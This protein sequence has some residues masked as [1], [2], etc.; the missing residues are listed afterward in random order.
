MRPCCVS[1][2]VPAAVAVACVAWS[3]ALVTTTTTV[4]G[5]RGEAVI[6]EDDAGVVHINTSEPASQSVYV[7]GVDVAE[8]MD[9]VSMQAGTL[10]AQQRRVQALC[11]RF[12]PPSVDTTSIPDAASDPRSR[13]W[14]G[15]V[16][17]PDGLLYG[18]PFAWNT[19]LIVD[20]QTKTMDRTTISGADAPGNKWGNG[21]LDVDTGLIFAFPHDAAAVLIINP[22]T[23]AID[24][25]TMDGLPSGGDKWLS[26]VQADNGLIYSVPWSAPSVL[27]IDPKTNTTDMSTIMGLG[28]ESFKW[29]GGA[30][31]P[32]NGLIYCIPRAA[33]AV[34]IIDPSTNTVDMSSMVVGAAGGSK[35]TGGVLA[36]SNG[37]IYGIPANAR[38]VLVID[39]STNTADNT[40][41]RVP[42][43]GG[44]SAA[45]GAGA[46]DNASLWWG[47]V[48]ARN[49]RIL[50]VPFAAQSVLVIDPVSQT[51]DTT[52]LSGILPDSN[53]DDKW[54]AGAMSNGLIACTPRTGASVLFINPGC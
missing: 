37:L 38:A 13:G 29:Y 48:L 27:I 33:A 31:A 50:G 2:I 44:A 47:G 32:S 21:V 15:F 3:L 52:T 34:L 10:Q 17:G 8:L 28:R 16:A 41:L 39:P 43:T 49:G 12:N 40:T 14:H 5:V 54:W 36:P 30:L 20:T 42:V 11:Q 22:A 1:A 23:N 6:A 53:N 4:A 7:N 35:W 19:V 9:V 18:I 26:G 24:T 45:S 51:L 25:S 46:E